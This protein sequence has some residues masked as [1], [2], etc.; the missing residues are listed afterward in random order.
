MPTKQI[1]DPTNT[2]RKPSTNVG[3]ITLGVLA[4]ILVNI[5]VIYTVWRFCLE[6]HRQAQARY[7][8]LSEMEME[9]HAMR[10]LESAPASIRYEGLL[11]PTAMLTVAAYR[12]SFHTARTKPMSLGSERGGRSF[13][14]AESWVSGGSGEG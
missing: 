4:G 10:R 1:W 12:D 14:T 6:P 3:A 7:A 5:I 11:W 2:P 9:N 13:V 8:R